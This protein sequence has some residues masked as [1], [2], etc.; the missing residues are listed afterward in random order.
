MRTLA[1]HVFEGIKDHDDLVGIPRPI[2]RAVTQAALSEAYGIT[3]SMPDDPGLEWSA[4]VVCDLVSPTED[5]IQETD[6]H[7]DDG[8][9]ICAGCHTHASESA[10]AK[11]VGAP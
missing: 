2:I 4:C 5:M 10:A 6:E 3:K 8:E 1:D 9:T 7:G 11:K